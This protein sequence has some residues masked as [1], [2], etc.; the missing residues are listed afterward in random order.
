MVEPDFIYSLNHLL[1]DDRIGTPG[2]VR[3]DLNVC[4]YVC[5]YVCM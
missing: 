3:L 5:M 2:Y 4:M 1:C